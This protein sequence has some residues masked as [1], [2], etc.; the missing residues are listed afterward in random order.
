MWETKLLS[1]SLLWSTWYKLVSSVE[2][3]TRMQAPNSN[4][5]W[6]YAA[7]SRS[8][9]YQPMPYYSASF[10]S[11]LWEGAKQWFYTHKDKLTTWSLCSTVF[12]A[13]FFAIG[14]TNA[15]RGKITSFQQQYNESVPEVWKHFQDYIIECPHHR[16]E[17]WLLMQPS[18]TGWLISPVRPWMLYW[19][20]FLIVHSESS[21]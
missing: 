5:F 3:H 7:P 14:K 1:S 4:T 16:M 11:H 20:C 15:L 10:H 2:R 13:K 21:Y 12:L 19:R 9:M 6:R 8:K 17:N 18:T